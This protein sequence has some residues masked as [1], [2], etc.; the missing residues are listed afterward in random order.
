[1]IARY[2]NLLLSKRWF[3]L[4]LLLGLT[5]FFLFKTVTIRIHTNFFEL[6]PPRHPFIK[7]Y[8]QFR[9]LF[10]TANLLSAIVEVEEGDIYEIP[11]FEKVD[12]I[13]RFLLDTKGVNPFQV[14]SLT[15]PSARGYRVRGYW[16]DSVPLVES[17][18]RSEQDLEEI[19]SK[20]EENPGIKGFLVSKDSR[21][22]LIIAGLWEEELDF[23][24]LW[25]RMEGIKA[26]EEGGVKIHL[27]GFPLLYTW[28]HHYL[29]SLF[30][31]FLLT[32]A[33]I[34]TLLYL[35]F[36]D[37]KGV[38]VPMA[39]GILSAIWGLGMA[40]FVGFSLDPLLLV[41]PV[42]LSARALSHSVQLMERYYDKFSTFGGEKEAI[43]G[44]FKALFKPATLSIVTDGLGILVIAV[45]GI[46]LMWRL[47]LYSSFWIVSIFIGVLTISPILLSFFSPPKRWSAIA[48]HRLYERFSSSHIVF[49]RTGR[50]RIMV[51]SLALLLIIG[52]GL[53]GRRL[54]VG[55]VTPGMAILSR[56]H[57][58]NSASRRLNEKFYGANQFIVV[59]EGKEQGVMK[60]PEV[61]RL[62]ER[63]ERG[64]LRETDARASVSPTKVVKRV[65][66]LFRENDPNWEVL[67]YRP[68]DVGAIG[69]T[70]RTGH[71]LSQLF[72]PDF[73]D[74]TITLYFDTYSSRVVEKVVNKA[75]ELSAIESS[76]KVRFRLAAGLLGVLSA[77][78]EE[79]ERSYWLILYLALGTIFVLAGIFFRS[80]TAPLILVP[81]L[82]LSQFLSEVFMLIV[83]IDMNINSLPVA[84]IGI[85]VGIDYGIY[86]LSRM[87]E[88]GSNLEQSQIIQNALKTTGKAILFTATTVVLSVAFWFLSPVKF[89]S[90][91]ALLLGLLMILNMEGALI[92]VPSLTSLLRRKGGRSRVIMS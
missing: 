17:L 53:L 52:G 88:E 90:E 4:S 23:P 29:P 85:G 3:F 68:R 6:Y 63:F 87:E 21:A 46:P 44:S 16:V 57:P 34:A 65:T 56:D 1:V 79:V 62:I 84:A 91:M 25:E 69:F 19:R 78:N 41:V 92:L 73:K 45:S 33:S 83:G 38:I 26:M 50:R 37:L 31:V 89:T 47:A 71:E 48:T 60:D 12:R 15:H 54:R 81:S 18:P 86:I 10:G 11:I 75:K 5:F 66:R 51:A 20:V 59:A 43:I 74:A 77:V 64:L 7:V 39:A 22:C 49:L 36:G 28:L 67:P 30:L 55:D 70:L 9:Q 14:L 72:S 32:I 27:T 24:Y 8:R 76:D 40:G 42:L 61:L 2:L 13:T 80:I 58:Y 82:I 35:F